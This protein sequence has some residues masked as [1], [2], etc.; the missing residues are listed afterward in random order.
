MKDSRMILLS[1]RS[2]E[3][4]GFLHQLFFFFFFYSRIL[5]FLITEGEN[6]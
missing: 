3:T 5:V 6:L 4:S 2:D 1:I